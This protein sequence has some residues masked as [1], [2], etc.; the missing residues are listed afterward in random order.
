MGEAEIQVS[1]FPT[2][3]RPDRAF[4]VGIA[5][6]ADGISAAKEYL[7]ELHELVDTLGIPVCGE[8]VAPVRQIH[9][10]YYVGSGKL[11]EIRDM[12]SGAGA[13][14]LIFDCDLGPSQQRNIE[15]MSS[16]RV[17]DRQEVI[18]DIFAARAQTREAVLQV[19]LARNRYYLPRLTGAWSHLS[20]QR[21][22]A[23]GTRGEGEKQ[24][25]YDR[26][27]VKK[28][29]RALEEDLREVRSHRSVQR[30]ERLRGSIVNCAIIGYTNA[31]KST[32]LNALTGAGVLAEDKFFATLDPTTRKLTLPDKSELLLTDTVG[33]VRKLPHSLVEA[34]KSTL[35]EAL[36]ADFV[37]LVLDVSSPYVSSHWETTLS[38]LNELGAGDKPM[39]TVF[40]KSDLLT[41]PVAQARVRSLSPDGIFVSSLTGAGFDALYQA[42]SLRARGKTA[43][44]EIALPPERQDLMALAHAK[45]RIYESEWLED[46]TFLAT[47]EFTPALGHR[48]AEFRR[49][50]KEK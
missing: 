17:Y 37:M 45:G 2:A 46:G 43:V 49:T 38:V 36:L 39:L 9:P 8:T 24:I 5:D 35:E 12:A 26:R 27:M 29:I 41:D 16:M 1:P 31:G 40:N 30:K 42:L 50:G 15:K 20:R 47:V 28:R 14:L 10:K 11:E 22:G 18:L 33:F 34:F 32:L 48:F 4:L 6:Q 7:S 25:E 3:S 13:D 23:L 44:M 21:G 19:E